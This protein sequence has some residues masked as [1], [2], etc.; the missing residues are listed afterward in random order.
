MRRTVDLGLRLCRNTKEDFFAI[1]YGSKKLTSAEQKYSTM[2]KQCLA[3]VWGV[4]KF[5]LYLPGKAFVLQTDHQALTFLKDAKFR[6][7]RTMRWGLALQGYDYT[8]KDISGK[9]N[10]VA[11]YLS[12]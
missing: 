4:S 7:D 5:R 11:D 8:V 12:R 9:D 1:T 2:E 6:N 10:V 3:I